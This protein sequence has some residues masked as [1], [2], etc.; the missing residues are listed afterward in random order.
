MNTGKKINGYVLVILISSAFGTNA[1]AEK[2][3]VIESKDGKLYERIDANNDGKKRWFNPSAGY[4]G[5]GFEQ[6]E[7][8]AFFDTYGGIL[9]DRD[10]DA[11]TK[12]RNDFR[13]D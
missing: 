7:Q 11:R 1:L 2:L 6:G 9:S 13:D 3:K 4:R 5:F 8:A 12:E 10:K